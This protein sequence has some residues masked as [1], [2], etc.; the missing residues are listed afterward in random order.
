MTGGQVVILGEVG[1]NFGAGMS[2]G[3]AYVLVD[4][5]DQ[6]IAQ[7]NREMIE[8]ESLVDEKEIRSLEDMIQKHFDYT[9]SKKAERILDNWEEVISKF[10]KVIPKDYKRMMERIEEQMQAGLTAEDAVMSAFEAN[11]I[12]EK[13]G[14]VAS[15]DRSEAIVQ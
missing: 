7:C 4:N 3:I 15:I 2:G 9:G 1:K 10:V 8:F 12:T 13:K 6:F 5:K 11:A 14:S